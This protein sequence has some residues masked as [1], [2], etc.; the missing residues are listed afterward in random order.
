MQNEHGA[1]LVDCAT[2]DEVS[3]YHLT[4][5]AG[6]DTVDVDVCLVATA[7]RFD[8]DNGCMCAG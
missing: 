6:T 7:R 3:A 2:V 1:M 4:M 5:S 8:Q